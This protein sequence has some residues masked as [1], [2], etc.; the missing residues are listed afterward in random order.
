M[1][2][3]VALIAATA[4]FVGL[5]ATLWRPLPIALGVPARALAAGAEAASMLGGLGLYLAGMAALGP[6]YDVS[7]EFGARVHEGQRLVTSGPY[8]VVRHPMYLGLAI[9]AVSGL[10]LYRTWTTLADVAALPVLVVRARREDEVLAE[11]FGH[12]WATYRDRVSEWIPRLACAT[13]AEDL[14]ARSQS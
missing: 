4:G 10:L 3:T 2:E 1:S 5:S 8:A 9:T 11:A 7:S 14:A 13:L 12:D 6:A